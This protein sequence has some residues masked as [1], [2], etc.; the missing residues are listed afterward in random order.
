MHLT[1]NVL[2]V[3]LEV[4]IAYLAVGVLGIR[5]GG[6]DVLA[7]LL[8]PFQILS[9]SLT[10]GAVILLKA[11]LVPLKIVIVREQRSSF[12]NVLD[13]SKPWQGV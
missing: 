11:L 8:V 6:L 5:N 2:L 1:G 3:I 9:D 10:V 4:S 7:S 13:S 12:R